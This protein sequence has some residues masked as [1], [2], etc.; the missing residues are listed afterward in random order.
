MLV[1]AVIAQLKFVGTFLVP[2][3]F[4][5]MIAI[6]GSILGVMFAQLPA[7]ARGTMEPW[8]LNLFAFIG[9]VTLLAG[10][11]L[12]LKKLFGRQPSISEILSGLVSTK[13]LAEYREEQRLRCVGLEK[14]ISDAR[15]SFDEARMS[16]LRRNEESFSKIFQ[17]AEQ[18]D[19]DLGKMRDTI[20]RL[21]ERTETHLRKLDQYDTKLDNLLREVSAAASRGVRDAQQSQQQS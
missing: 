18:R 4:P 16:D 8:L 15:H 20:S 1:S 17:L 13:T 19:R 11:A 10:L 9:I 12:T 14:Q 2:S 21:Q 5:S 3:F 7:P 6:V